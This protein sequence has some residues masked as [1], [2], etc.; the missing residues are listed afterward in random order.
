[1]NS[2]PTAVYVTNLLP[3]TSNQPPDTN[4]DEELSEASVIQLVT[5]VATSNTVTHHSSNAL[6]T[7]INRSSLMSTIP[8]PAN[9]TDQVL[10]PV[11]PR[12]RERIIKGKNIDFT[13]LLPKSPAVQS[14]IV[15]P[16]LQFSYHTVRATSLS[17][18]L[19]N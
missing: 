4:G 12:I 17:A 11:P 15:P 3:S 13:M 5:P 16:H 10:P 6:P 8:T 1:M 14:L 9:S 18:Q 7:L 19:P 2:Q